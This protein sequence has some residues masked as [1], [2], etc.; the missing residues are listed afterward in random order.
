MSENQVK[1]TKYLQSSDSVAIQNGT[2]VAVVWPT[3]V[4]EIEGE[5][6]N[7]L[8]ETGATFPDT[9][10]AL[11]AIDA[12]FD[13]AG[14]LRASE[15]LA[16]VFALL[17]GGRRGAELR[18]ALLGTVDGAGAEMARE[19]NISPVTWHKAIHRLRNRLFRKT[20]NDRP[21]CKGSEPARG[22]NKIKI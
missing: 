8:R 20:A 18:A 21:M 13:Q 9:A 22:K 6:L 17:P 3:S 7:A 16:R 4:I 5:L 15:T 14:D 12:A 11:A 19:F 2:P 1:N 10:G